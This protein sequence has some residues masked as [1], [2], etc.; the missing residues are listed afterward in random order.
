MK[1]NHNILEEL[2]PKPVWCKNIC[3]N[4]LWEISLYKM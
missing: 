2:Q 4:I 1:S 3:I